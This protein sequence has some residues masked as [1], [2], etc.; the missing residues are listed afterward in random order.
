VT[1]FSFAWCQIG[2]DG[3][4]TKLST[5]QMGKVRIT[6]EYVGYPVNGDKFTTLHGQKGVVTILPDNMVPMAL[7]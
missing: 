2:F 3:R 6:L 4:V 7:V 1:P 5:N